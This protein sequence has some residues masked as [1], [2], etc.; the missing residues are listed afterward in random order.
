MNILHVINSSNPAGGG[1]IE[2]IVQAHRALAPHGHA[3]ELACVDPP[4]SAWLSGFAFPAHALGPARTKY[5]YAPGLR[6][7]IGREAP[8][9]DCAIVHGIWLYPSF[10][11][12]RALRGTIV[13]Y[14]IYTHGL[15]DPVFRRVF[16]LKHI[17]KMLSWKL[18]E[19]HVV[20]DARA[21]FF[22]CEEEQR[23]A[24]QS[25]KPYRARGAIVP[26]CVGEPP[27]DPE[28]QKRAFLDR[29]PELRGR[30]VLL[31]LSRIHPKKGCDLLIRA[32][33]KGAGAD[34]ALHLVVAGPDPVEWRGSL[35]ELAKRLG[36]GDRIT[37]TGML[38]GDL[39]WGAFRA[40]EAFVLP[41]HQENYG[42][43]VVEALACGTP[44]LIS[45]K[46]NIWREI[47]A[48]GAGWVDS[49]DEDGA[50]RLLD[51][52]RALPAAERSLLRDRARRCFATRFRSEEAGRILLDT[53]R[54]HGVQESAT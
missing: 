39:K 23:L 51:R 53:L 27:G 22:T 32:L 15:L 21:L 6:P 7:W 41:S 31:F 12:W 37:W 19:Q 18:V 5:R 20:R 43:A 46:I 47:E 25:F 14:F 44:V 42:I 34:P 3:F 1:P 29:F 26:Y 17:Y 4:G 2:S 48:D 9:F 11:T 38:S 50:G 33:A 16:P 13:P 49:D 40:A 10:A 45:H 36:V 35:E 24:S 30:R 8:R 54:R 52:W 28:A